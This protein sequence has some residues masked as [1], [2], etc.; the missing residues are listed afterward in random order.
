[1]EIIGERLRILREQKG[2][3]QEDI[4]KLLGTTQQIYSRYETNR[5]DLPMRH[6]LSL[7]SYY[8]VSADYI[9]GRIPYSSMTPEYSATFLKN[10][11][12]GD[13]VCRIC[14]FNNTSKK[15]LIDY[16]NYLT[17]LETSEKRKLPQAGPENPGNNV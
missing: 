6:L 8:N 9:L 3:T 14:S 17:Y 12:V 15:M 4:S 7:A 11:T 16:V 5:N 10:V 1:M 13:F 2:K